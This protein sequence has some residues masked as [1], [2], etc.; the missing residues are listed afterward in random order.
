[1]A[2]WSGWLAGSALAL[3]VATGS[4]AGCARPGACGH[5]STGRRTRMHRRVS[6]RPEPPAV[7]DDGAEPTRR[8]S[9]PE[10][11]LRPAERPTDP[12]PSTWS[13]GTVVAT[14]SGPCYRVETDDGS[15]T[16]ST[17]PYLDRPTPGRQGR[18]EVGP[19][20]P[21]MR[22][23]HAARAKAVTIVSEPEVLSDPASV[24]A[25]STSPRVKKVPFLT[26]QPRRMWR[27]WSRTESSTVEA[28]RRSS[29]D[30]RPSPTSRGTSAARSAALRSTSAAGPGARRWAHRPRS[31]APAPPLLPDRRAGIVLGLAQLPLEVAHRSPYALL[32]LLGQRGQVGHGGVDL[33][34]EL[35]QLVRRAR[36]ARPGRRR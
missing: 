8:L 25:P 18:R 10:A 24:R 20:E 36:P 17:T 16:T 21:E 15:C 23:R 34:L 11:A 7:T 31:G 6:L 35:G 30:A 32:D 22:D 3:T 13:S 2:R 26:T 1:M 28:T 5:A 14:S 27:S 9:R 33:G 12:F 29:A 4:L 19:L